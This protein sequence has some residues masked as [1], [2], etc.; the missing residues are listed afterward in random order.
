MFVSGGIENASCPRLWWEL[1]N[2]HDPSSGDMSLDTGFL[3]W[4]NDQ[5][6]VT[7]VRVLKSGRTL[8]HTLIRLDLLHKSPPGWE[9]VRKFRL[10]KHFCALL[11][12][13]LPLVQSDEPAEVSIVSQLQG[14]DLRCFGPKSDVVDII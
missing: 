10:L 8:G 7:W 12:V 13:I 2:V 9:F 5:Y 4:G 1:V 11:T 3:L 6:S 14:R